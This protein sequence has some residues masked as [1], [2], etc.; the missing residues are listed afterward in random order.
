MR[1]VE[2]HFWRGWEIRD[3]LVRHDSLWRVSLPLPACFLAEEGF[4][5]RGKRPLFLPGM[6]TR[7]DVGN[8][9]VMLG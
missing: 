1:G 6:P 3:F 7:V 2:R 5:L 4:I 9:P 8:K